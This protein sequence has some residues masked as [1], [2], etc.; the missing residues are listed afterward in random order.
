MSRTTLAEQAQRQL[1][2]S[3]YL[4]VIGVDGHRMNEIHGKLEL[5]V[6]YYSGN[7]A[8]LLF[9]DV[10]RLD[11]VKQ[12]VAEHK[13]NTRKQTPS[14]QYARLVRSSVSV[15]NNRS[16]LAAKSV[17]PRIVNAPKA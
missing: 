2:S 9:P 5:C 7:R 16:S 13:L 1:P 6:R 15:T 14:Q 8:W 12:Y 10:Q 4:I 3:E 17:H 11:L